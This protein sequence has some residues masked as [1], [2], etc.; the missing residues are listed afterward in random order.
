MSSKKSN[1]ALLADLLDFN[2]SPEAG[3]EYIKTDLPA[4]TTETLLEASFRAEQVIA[5]ARNSVDFLSALAMPTIYEYAYPPIYLSVWDWLL[6]H[7]NKVRDFSQL[8]L[9]LPRG[10]AKTTLMKLFLLYCIIFTDRKF[11]LVIAE[12]G[13]KAEAIIADVMDMLR[14]PNIITTFGDYR[15]GIEIDRQNVKKFGFRG[16]NVIIAGIGA[17][18]DP[19]GLNIKHQRPDIMLF[20]DIQSREEADSEILS[21]KLERWM[22]GTVMKA[23]SPRGCMFLF[24]A[25]MYPTKFS[26]LRKL[27]QNKNWTKFIVG[28]I[29]ASGESLWEELQPIKQL[30]QE[31]ENDL[32]AGHPE[33]FYAEVL[34][35]ENA[36]VNNLIDFSALPKLP[37]EQGDIPAG[38]FII[39]DPATGKLGSDD[40]AIGYFEIYDT[41]PVG[42]KVLNGRFSPG[43]MIRLSLQLALEKNCRLIVCEGVAYQ[44]TALYWFDFICQQLG[45]SGI[46]LAE[47]HPGGTNK[48]S[49]ILSMFKSLREGD[50]FI[51]PD[52]YSQFVN[53][54]IQFNPL[55]RDNTDNILDLF[56][57]AP[58]VLAMFGEF[59]V[60]NNE[61]VYQDSESIALLPSGYNTA[62]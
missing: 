43:E 35:D 31:Y 11:I 44:A 41:K 55:R 25:N 28:G 59:V 22:I 56:T 6:E 38:N 5:N 20:D 24:V 7:V 23:K 62:F 47:I 13:P 45:I 3:N 2:V 14:E 32:E 9:G 53:E 10:F 50:I 48:N 40:V 27:K 34:N 37:Y 30:L 15:I 51:G 19:R 39:I 61:L 57:Y 8:A 4:N 46:E 58:K 16:R 49:R 21:S 17:N 52:C 12:T 42:I 36:S 33:I 54:A 18:G 60:S 1:S 29:L 26:L